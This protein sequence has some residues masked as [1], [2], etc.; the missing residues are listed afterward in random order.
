MS[1]WFLR[2]GQALPALLALG[3]FLVSTGALAAD[4]GEDVNGAFL[5]GLF[6]QACVPNRGNVDKIK[7]FA[8]THHF[9]PITNPEA[10]AV[11]AGPGEYGKAWQVPSPTHQHFALSIR[12]T[13]EACAVWAQ[14]ADAAVVSGAFVKEIEAIAKPGLEV[15]KQSE[16]TAE[17]QFGKA[18][19]ISYLVWASDSKKGFDFTLTT[20]ERAGGDFQASI[21]MAKVKLE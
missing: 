7:E 8:F 3:G 20:T 18:T 17:T 13:T 10:L 4:T 2:C 6:N 9:L 11:F 21:Q 12:G 14:T 15:K 5:I 19:T 16:E 1:G